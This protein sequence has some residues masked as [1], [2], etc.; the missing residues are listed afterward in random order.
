ML[1]LPALIGAALAGCGLSSMTSGI[2]GGM[3]GG[4]SSPANT[5]V[6]SVT[7]EQLLQ[8]AKADG[9]ASGPISGELSQ[10][11]PRF[12]VWPRDNTVTIFE[13][14]RIGDGLAVMHRGEITKT[15][16]ECRIESGR[17]VVRYGFS[18]RVLL[19]PKGKSGTVALPITV[20]VADAKRERITADKMKVDVAVA[21]EK[22]IGYFSIVRTISFPLPEGSRP[23]EFDVFVG[24]ERNLPNAG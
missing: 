7:E 21:I 6:G 22:P 20:F 24:L 2:G 19:G 11:C 15:A 3:L 14:G 8:A 10:G 12:Q 1:T 5:E 18:G 9:G 13:P 16:R 4:G 23:A 17:V